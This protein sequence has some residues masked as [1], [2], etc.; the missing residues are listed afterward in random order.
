MDSTWDRV[1]VTT[2][3]PEMSYVPRELNYEVEMIELPR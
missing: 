3:C 2:S 1:S